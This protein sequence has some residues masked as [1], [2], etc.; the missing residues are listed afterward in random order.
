MEKNNNT[1]LFR[2]PKKQLASFFQRFRPYLPGILNLSAASLLILYLCIFSYQN[3]KRELISTEQEQLLTMA[4]TVGKSL[5]HYVGQE[6]DSMDLYYSSLEQWVTDN[7]GLTALEAASH[8]LEKKTALYDAVSIYG[9]D[10][11]LLSQQGS[12]QFAPA[13]LPDTDTAAICG[14]WLSPGGWYQ[15]YIARRFRL[16]GQ[17][18]TAVYAMNLNEIHRQIVAPVKIGKGGYSVVKDSSLSIIMHHAPSQIGMDAVYDRRLRYPQLDLGDLFRWINRQKL[19]SEGCDI[20]QSYIW[21][22]PSLEPQKR[23]V[24]YTTIHLP[25]EDWIVNST[26][27]YEEL[28]RPLN[29]MVIRLAGI[30]LIFLCILIFYVYIMTRSQMRAEGQKKEIEYLKEINA[31]MELLRHKEEEIQHYQRIQSIGQMSSHIAHEFNNYLTPVIVYGELLEGDPTIGPPQQE[32][33]HGILNSA[34][35]AADLSRKLLDFSRQDSGVALTTINLTEDVQNACKIIR[36]L[37]PQPVVFHTEITKTPLYISGRKG[38][39][40]HILM[41]LSNNAFHAMEKTNDR[42]NHLVVS[43]TPDTPLGQGKTPEM[44]QSLSE[45]VLL[46]VKDTGCGISKDAMDKIFEPF[47]TTKRSGKGTGLG[48]SV[49][50]NIM[51][52]CAGH[53]EIESALG[54]GTTF[55]LYFPRIQESPAHRPSRTK[56]IQKIVVVDDDPEIFK[57]LGMFLRNAGYQCECCGHPAAVLS[58][59]QQQKGYCDAILTDYAMPSMNGLEFAGLVRKL[60]PEI[61]LILMSGME[62]ARFEWYLKNKYIDHFFLKSDLANLLLPTLEAAHPQA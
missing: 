26:L 24:A 43:L 12:M 33:V 60:N 42:E 39:M 50:R 36:Q 57:T 45:W 29:S 49:V 23:I 15:M 30:S 22:T 20:I 48:L 58:H 1:N 61:L 16:G 3:Y 13:S 55:K 51:T 11:R 37:T 2:H 32:M 27:P 54:A 53:I 56:K 25:G 35:Q 17:E 52:A 6:L 47:Y 44:G 46:S 19:N 10:K 34:G 41:N 7:H 31:G 18:Y 9:P 21:D 8:F 4:Q 40:E 59:I 62:D 5:V 38:M 14:K 28:E